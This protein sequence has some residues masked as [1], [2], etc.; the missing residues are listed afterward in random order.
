MYLTQ[1]YGETERPFSNIRKNL[2]WSPE[3]MYIGI[4]NSILTELTS[5]LVAL[6]TSLKFSWNK[7]TK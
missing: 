5:F 6:V 7:K 2:I 1:R 4:S 3:H